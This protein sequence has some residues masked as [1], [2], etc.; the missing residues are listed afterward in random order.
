MSIIG[1]LVV[2]AIAGWVASRVVPGNE[3]YGLLGGLAAGVVGAIVGGWLFG[4]VTNSNWM[5]SFDLGSIVA[6]IV[7]AIIVVVIWNAIAGRRGSAV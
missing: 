1:W 5:D 7:G 2:G 4:L 6:A 3:G